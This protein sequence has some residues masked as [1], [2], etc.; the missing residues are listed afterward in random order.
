[1]RRICFQWCGQ[2]FNHFPVG[3]IEGEG[4]SPGRAGYTQNQDHSNQQECQEL[5]ERCVLYQCCVYLC[6]CIMRVCARVMCVR[7]VGGWVQCVCACVRAVGG[8][9][10]VC[11][12]ATQGY[13]VH[14]HVCIRAYNRFPMYRQ[15]VCNLMLACNE[16]N[17]SPSVSRPDTQC[18]GRAPSCEGTHSHAHQ[19][20]PYH[21]PQDTLW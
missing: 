9:V 15:T 17:F 2:R 19:D 4:L 11:S 7:V 16:L 13:C 20:P 21:H 12:L 10:R 5:G 8:W 14:V 6:I 18:Q 3:R 1:M